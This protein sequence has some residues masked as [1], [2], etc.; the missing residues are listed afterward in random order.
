V[1]EKSGKWTTQ[2]D[3][4]RNG[5]KLLILYHS[6]TGNT[7]FACEVARLV[8][9]Q[10]GHE[11]IMKTYA[12]AGDL[13][14]KEF[15]AYCFGAPVYEWAPARNVEQYLQNMMRLDGKCAFI[16]TSSAGAKGQATE[17]LAR[18]LEKKGLA[19]L[20]DHN[21]I[22]PDSWGGTR[23]W[24]Y[25]QDDETPTVDSVRELSDFTTRM[26]CSI[27][28]SVEGRAAGLPEYR[29]RPT[30]LYWASRLSRLA[31]GPRV[32]MGKKKVDTA[33]CTECRVCEKNCPVGAIEL[34]PFPSF[35]KKCIACWRCI[36][37]C[38]QDCIST[39]L[40]GG[41]HYK[42]IVHKDDLLKKAGFK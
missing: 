28:D 37:T 33:A 17:L 22:C 2:F 30:G 26:L 13:D 31:P 9:E 27:E 18:M 1:D 5:L 34:D 29:V 4:A 7:R 10:A 12:K 38:P 21:L 15:D 36:N 40:D 8:V 25:K 39:M 16:I 35:G 19:L 23:R 41:H 32:K 14:L 6:G 3:K 24:S 42:G 11:V 20:G